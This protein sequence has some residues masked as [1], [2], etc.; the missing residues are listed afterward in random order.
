M[1]PD[2]KISV[3][4]LDNTKFSVTLGTDPELFSKLTLFD[5]KTK[6]KNTVGWT[7][8]F[9]D[10]SL[11]LGTT[12]LKNDQKTLVSYGIKANSQLTCS[13]YYNPFKH[14][15]IKFT[16]AP[17]AITGDNSGPLRA[18]L[19][20][21]HAVDPNSLT[22]YC[23]SLIDDGLY[24]FRC[25]ALVNNSKCNK[26]WN[27]EEVRRL[28]L[29]NNAEMEFFERKISELAAANYIDFKTCPNCQSFVERQDLNNLRVR[30]FCKSAK[31][32]LFEFCWQCDEKWDGNISK[33]SDSCGKAG[34]KDKNIDAL[35]KCD[36]IKLKSC[37]ELPEIPSLRACVT[38]GMIVEHNGTACK[39]VIC[40]RCKTEFCFV[41]LETTTECQ[42]L[43]PGSYYRKCAKSLQ[44]IQTNIPEWKK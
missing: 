20:C 3:F 24:E 26:I 4:S 41:C 12:S 11:Y 21:G 14:F 2:I 19:S 37:P 18:L 31:G 36:L 35:A 23:R 44:P 16:D 30:C 15:E 8:N 39:N 32:Q 33:S 38:C 7:D 6:I 17:D 5:L 1:V 28:A 13:K 42:R 9:D 10:V 29:L 27:Y 43:M 34:C 22:G 25:P 40:P